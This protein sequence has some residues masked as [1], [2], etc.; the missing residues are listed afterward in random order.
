MGQCLS[1]GEITDIAWGEVAASPDVARHLRACP[2]C[3]ARLAQARRL[4]D[5]AATLSSC[6]APPGLEEAIRE[7]VAGTR[8]ARRITCRA[9]R[10]HLVE[11]IDGV[12]GGSLLQ[13]VEAHLFTCDACY[14]EYRSLLELRCAAQALQPASPPD[15]LRDRIRAAVAASAATPVPARS[16]PSLARLAWGVAAMALIAAVLVAVHLSAPRTHPPAAP[17]VTVGVAPA[18]SAHARAAETQPALA[19]THPP[20]RPQLRASRP[21]PK[22]RPSAGHATRPRR[23]R[24]TRTRAEPP[25]PL[26]L[27]PVS[28]AIEEP[29]GPPAPAPEA[30]TPVIAEAPTRNEPAGVERPTTPVVVAEAPPTITPP[31]ATSSPPPAPPRPAAPSPTAPPP[32]APSPGPRAPAQPPPTTPPGTEVAPAPPEP[33]SEVAQPETPPEHPRP[34]RLAGRVGQTHW[35]PVRESGVKRVVVE[36]P[37]ARAQLEEAAERLNKRIREDMRADRAGWIAIK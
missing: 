2:T 3:A 1:W 7:A 9:C 17:E 5:A 19:S 23:T 31:P 16:R 12:L 6:P 29:P 35:L 20:K 25:A 4:A 15:G 18:P 37:P 10:R 34:V 13:A 36:P 30:P 26:E 24:T 28:P 27:E 8:P 22:P 21:S 14:A 11:Y 33:P 32:T